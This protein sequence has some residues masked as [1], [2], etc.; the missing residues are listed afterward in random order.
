[1]STTIESL[2][3]ELISNSTSAESGITALAKSLRKLR[4]AAKDGAGL[5]AVNEQLSKI[6]STLKPA[7]AQMRNFSENLKNASTNLKQFSKRSGE[8]ATASINL[9]AKLTAAYLVIKKIVDTVKGV[10]GKISNYIEQVNLFNVAMGKYA[11]EA[12][13]YAEEVSEV[14]GIDPGEWMY[15]Q[16]IFMTLATGFGVASD[17]AATM[18]KN[19]TQLGYDISSFYNIDLSDAM[20]KLQSGLAGELE[21]LRRI[22]YDLSQAKLEATAL[23]LGIDKSVSSMTQAEK[24][25]LRYHAIMTQVTTVQGDMARTLEQ[26]ANQMRIFKAQIEMLGRAFGSI[27]IPVLNKVLPYLIAATQVLRE[28]V[29]GIASLVGFEMPTVDDSDVSVMGDVA[30]NTS[31]AMES[32]TESAK[33]LKSY[34]MGFD[35]LNVINPNDSSTSGESD[36]I[37]A[38]DIDLPEYDFLAGAVESR[39][40]K[41]VDEMKEWLGITDDI[42]SWSELLDT[43]FGNILK[44]IGYI[45]AGIVAWKVTKVFLDSITAI[46]ELLS[47]PS[48]AITISAILT[49]VGFAISFEGMSDAI[50]NGLDGFNFV[51][52]VAGA[53]LGTGGAAL[54]GSKIA[55]WITTAFS[56]SKVAS[57]LTIAAKNLGV[58]T[59]TAAGGAI[60]AAISGIILGIPMYFVGI[61]DAIKNG[62]DWLSSILIPAGATAAGAGIGAIIGMLGGPIGAGIGALIGLAV[63]LVTDLVIL[64]VQKWDEICA[65]FVKIGEW[66]YKNVIQPIGNFFVNLWEDIKS[67]WNTVATWFNKNIIQP[68]V[69]FFKGLW[70]SIAGFFENLW[71]NIKGIWSTVANWFNDKVITPLVNFFAPIVEWIST[72]FYGCWIIIQAVWVVVSTWFNERVVQP[73]VGFFKGLW[74][75]VSGFFTSLWNDIVGI[76]NGV[77]TWFDM[78][79]IQPVVGFFKGLW[80]TVSGFFTSLWNDVKNIW[81][82][83]ST[84]FNDYVITPVVGFFKGLVENVSSFFVNLWDGIKGVW[85]TVATWFDTTIIEPVTTAF[86]TACDMIGDFFES[87]WLGIKRGVVGAMNGVISAIEAVINGIISGING[88]VKGFNKVVS[89][90]ADIIGAD[91]GG[92]TLIQKVSFDKIP[93]PTYAEGGFPTSG[94]AFIARENG[95]PEM[96]GTIGRRTA[97]AN[98]DQIVESISVGV[99]EANSE[100]NSLLR[101]QNALLRALLEKDSGVY[102]DGRSLSDSVDKY[103][104]EQ[105]RVLIT[106]G[107]L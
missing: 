22:G 42:D 99:A 37:G 36:T 74:E 27:F 48:Y 61:Y 47:K 19:L 30:E 103:K 85:N 49:I 66:F 3:L 77:A 44:T 4:S 45:G 54:L 9:A 43:R 33:K 78:Y 15:N 20:D 29:S 73:V 56:G 92:L 40:A 32:A 83:V 13:A 86:E 98:N 59:A 104:R 63:G 8:S 6:N 26:P 100:Q 25:M 89:W 68:L 17:K 41:I 70:K 21:P 12:K 62:L 107:V 38:L 35:E 76:W 11:V 39:V 71:D 53:L 80:E 31:D 52:I 94:Q 67:I 7:A 5:S 28:L 64:I 75:T 87:L 65:F 93:M 72:F 23:S 34:M 57:A 105:G 2:E 46:T 69:E 16:G 55:T 101:E 97:V 1:M 60:A 84:W 106:G 81:N 82:T 24:A 10:I 90:A 91:W 51:E 102:L 50:K 18:S 14:M 58:G 88:L 96:V 95:I 79:V